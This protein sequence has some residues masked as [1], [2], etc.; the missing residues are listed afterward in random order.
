[1]KDAKG[2][3]IIG[4]ELTAVHTYPIKLGQ[5]VSYRYAGGSL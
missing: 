4:G 5:I 3:I 1:M 2:T